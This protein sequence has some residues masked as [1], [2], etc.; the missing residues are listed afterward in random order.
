MEKTKQSIPQR[1]KEDVSLQRSHDLLR[2]IS[3]AQSQYISC[4][5][6][7]H[8]F[9]ELLS[10]LLSLTESAYGFIGEVLF[11]PHGAPFLKMHAI[12]NI[13]WDDETRALYEKYEQQGME[14]DNLNTLF[15]AALKTRQP[16]ISNAPADDPRRGG[17]PKGHPDLKAFLGLPIHP[18]WSPS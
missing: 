7:R 18:T 4:A 15:G 13:A 1:R 14:F 12:T 10:N 17:L 9:G 2:A 11:R 5:D 16:V 6:S 3:N 8:L